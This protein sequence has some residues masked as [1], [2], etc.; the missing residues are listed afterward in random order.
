MRKE[1]EIKLQKIQKEIKKRI[2]SNELNKSDITDD[3]EDFLDEILNES[4]KKT[5]KKTNKEKTKFFHKGWLQFWRP[6]SEKTAAKHP[7]MYEKVKLISGPRKDQ[8]VWKLK[9]EI[10]DRPASTKRKA[11]QAEIDDSDPLTKEEDEAE[12][13]GWGDQTEAE[14]RRSRRSIL[15]RLYPPDK[16][17]K[18]KEATKEVKENLE[19]LKSV[20]VERI[21]SEKNIKKVM[22][23]FKMSKK[24]QAILEKTNMKTEEILSSFISDELVLKGKI[25]FKLLPYGNDGVTL[26]Y[27]AIDKAADK[28]VDIERSFSLNPKKKDYDFLEQER[29][30]AEHSLFYLSEELGSTGIGK[31]ILNKSIDF[32]D[33]IGI[34]R[35]ELDA[36]LA[37]GKYIWARVGFETTDEYM[38]K[39][40]VRDFEDLGFSGIKD[41]HDIANKTIT[42]KEYE[43]KYSRSFKLPKHAYSGFLHPQK[44]K[45]TFCVSGNKIKIG[46]AYMLELKHMLPMKIDLNSERG[47]NFRKYVK[48]KKDKKAKTDIPKKETFK[49]FRTLEGLKLAYKRSSKKVDIEEYKKKH[50]VKA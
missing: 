31:K 22:K 44:L 8:M 14:E 37:V 20:K 4:K 27:K 17:T 45:N 42:K 46:K 9:Q 29:K 40:I 24:M 36:G 10:L 49:K 47:E 39:S 11:T 33:K 32:Y 12:D 18:I 2:G 48:G 3:N 26:K 34:E 35:I 28:E 5:K 15:D 30:T 6:A 43:E 23:D 16:K 13:G 38:E 7:E 25:K 50:L 41:L 1:L 19:K 21:L